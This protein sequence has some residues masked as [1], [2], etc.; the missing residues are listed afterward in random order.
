MNTTLA[1]CVIFGLFSVVMLVSYLSSRKM[2]SETFFT[3]NHSSPWYVVAFGMIGAS[4]S[5]ITFISVP[6]EVGVSGWTYLQFIFGNFVGYWI[7]ALVFIPLYFKLNLVSIYT[8]L[9]KRLGVRTYKTGSF[10]FIISQ[11]HRTVNPLL[12]SL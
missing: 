7:I 11:S 12:R 10:F 4:I 6:G 8:Y 5:G 3:G 9:E 2:N 1:F